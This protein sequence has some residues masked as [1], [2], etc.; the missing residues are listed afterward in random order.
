MGEGRKA[1]LQWTVGEAGGGGDA[2]P[3]SARCP[4]LPI[5]HCTPPSPI[6][7]VSVVPVS[8]RSRIGCALRSGC[9]GR[10]GQGPQHPGA[11][12]GEASSHFHS[13]LP[14]ASLAGTHV[15]ASPSLILGVAASRPDPSPSKWEF[16][17]EISEALGDQ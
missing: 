16:L 1:M 14:G 6:P 12:E 13:D 5:S 3:P 17:K 11:W 7:Q 2:A 15:V 8:G 9:T 10:Q 4:P